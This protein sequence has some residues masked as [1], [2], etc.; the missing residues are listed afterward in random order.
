[1]TPVA[2]ELSDK[3]LGQPYPKFSGRP[4][5][6]MIL[7]IGAD[8]VR[9]MVL[10]SRPPHTQ[11]PGSS[12]PASWALAH[13]ALLEEL[14]VRTL[15]QVHTGDYVVPPSLSLVGRTEMRLPGVRNNSGF[16]PARRRP[17]EWAFAILG[18]PSNLRRH[19]S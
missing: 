17:T 3:Y 13:Y 4:D 12:S 6:R 16:V 7:T 11:L 14:H 2:E 18:D 9:G 5:T 1:M 10:G 19:W 8:S 15:G